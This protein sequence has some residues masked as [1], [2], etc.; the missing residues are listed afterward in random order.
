MISGEEQDIPILH[1]RLDGEK[2]RV[3]LRSLVPASDLDHVFICGP[4]GIP[5]GQFTFERSTDWVTFE[6]STF[7]NRGGGGDCDVAT[8]PNGT[9]G[10]AVYAA[11][12]QAWGSALNVSLDWLADP[13]TDLVEEEELRLYDSIQRMIETLGPKKAFERLVRGEEVR[14]PAAGEADTKKSFNLGRPDGQS[15]NQ[16]KRADKKLRSSG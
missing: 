12:L 13:T 1:G 15:R 4:V 14:E 10:D 7:T 11:N 8:G 3:L 5:G 16:P 9:G 2:V 6:H